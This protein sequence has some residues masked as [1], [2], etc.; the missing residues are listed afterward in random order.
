MVCLMANS[1]VF[2]PNTFLEKSSTASQFC[3]RGL[4]EVVPR[5]A[6]ENR[7]VPRVCPRNAAST[8]LKLG[9]ESPMGPSCVVSSGT[10]PCC[11][12]MERG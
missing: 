3:T 11:I 1:T 10:R 6:Q 5:M 9:S 8:S 4:M 2:V 12:D 7:R